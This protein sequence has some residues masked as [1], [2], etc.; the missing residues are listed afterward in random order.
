[1]MS[2]FKIFSNFYT[3][4]FRGAILESGSGLMKGAYVSNA[5]NYSFQ[6]GQLLNNYLQEGDSWTLLST[7]RSVSPQDILG[8]SQWV[9]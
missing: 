1:M 7:L 8:A 5:R 2:F 3:G 6:L 9:S 4:L